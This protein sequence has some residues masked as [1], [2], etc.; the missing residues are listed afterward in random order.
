MRVIAFLGSPRKDGNTELLLNEAIKGVKVSV[1]AVQVFNLN[2]MKISPC[3]DCGGCD[4]TGECIVEDEMSQIYN[5]IRTA[6]RIILA[7][8]VFF[9]GLSAQTKIMIDRCQAFWCEKYLLKK[10]IPEGEFGRKGLLLLVGGMEKEAGIKCSEATARAFFRT[11]SVPEHRT[12]SFLGVDAKG[13]IL[14]HPTALKETYE[15][16]K[17]LVNI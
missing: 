13:V 12:L 8:P 6:D 1:S 5:A 15:A 11:I 2:L 10:P 16:G 9:F 14:Q 4:E 17:E 7:S 3:Q